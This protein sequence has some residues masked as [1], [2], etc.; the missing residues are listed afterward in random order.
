LAF[1]GSRSDSSLYILSTRPSLIF[2]LIYVGNIIVTGLDPAAIQQLILSFQQVFALKDLSPLHYFLGVKALIDLQGLFLT[3]RKYI[4]DLLKCT[5]MVDAKPVTSPMSSSVTFSTYSS[6]A[7][8][9]PS[10]YLSVVGSLQYLS[11]TRP[12]LSFAVNKVCQFMHQPIV[13]H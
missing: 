8:S 13:V 12:D 1:V 6:E 11:L 10:L 7:F 2:F 5:N 3:Q 4:L 9:D